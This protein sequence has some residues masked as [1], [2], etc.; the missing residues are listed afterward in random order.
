MFMAHRRLEWLLVALMII[1]LILV[2]LSLWA[3]KFANGNLNI[4]NNQPIF[5]LE[6]QINQLEQSQRAV[7][8]EY[9]FQLK[10]YLILREEISKIS[11]SEAE[12]AQKLAELEQQYSQQKLKELEAK[13]DQYNYQITQLKRKRCLAVCS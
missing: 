3:A 1:A 10:T 11:Y 9:A 4:W 5:S 12:R 6:I 13:I 2:M 7:K 8:A